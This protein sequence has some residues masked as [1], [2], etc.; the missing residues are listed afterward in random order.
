[1]AI[2]GHRTVSV[3]SR[4]NVTNDAD[5]RTALLDRQNC[6]ATEQEHTVLQ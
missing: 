4:Y 2:S 1:M 5:V 6:S 3:F